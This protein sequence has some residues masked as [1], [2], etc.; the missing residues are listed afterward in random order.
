MLYTLISAYDDYLGLCFDDEQIIRVIGDITDDTLD[1]RIDVNGLPR[2]Y[3][4]VIDE[5]LNFS[6]PVMEKADKNKNMP[7]LEVHLGRLFLSEKA[8][9]VLKS[10]IENDGEFLPVTYENGQGYFYIPLQVAA[11]DPNLTRKNEWDEIVNL[12]FNEDQVKDYA[13]FRTEYNGYMRLY[14][15]ES[16]KNIIESEKLTGLY[17][18]NDLANIFPED[19][20]S[21]AQIN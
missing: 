16:V 19:R 11:V 8:Y 17:I 10:V 7:D 4:G 12:G 1:K 2:S 3:K 20:G 5:L 18:T 15:Q 14:A 9:Q 13:L 6:F 21:V